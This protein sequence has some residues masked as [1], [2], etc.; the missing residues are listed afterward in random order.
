LAQAWIVWYWGFGKSA[1]NPASIETN[2]KTPHIAVGGRMQTVLGEAEEDTWVE[3]GWVGGWAE[4]VVDSCA[5]ELEVTQSKQAASDPLNA[6]LGSATNPLSVWSAFNIKQVSPAKSHDRHPA[7]IEHKA[8]QPASV[9]SWGL[10]L[11]S[12]IKG[13][14]FAEKYPTVLQIAPAGGMHVADGE[15]VGKVR[16]LEEAMEL[17]P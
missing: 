13:A 7:V 4:E 3:D 10:M 15:A 14:V 6:P 17:E 12:M 5:D 9:I 11:C 2:P 8:L 16:V 1:I